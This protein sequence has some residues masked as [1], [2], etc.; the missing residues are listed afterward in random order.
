MDIREWAK[1]YLMDIDP[2]HAYSLFATEIQQAQSEVLI[3]V[4]SLLYLEYL[5]EIGLI[6]SVKKAQCN[7][8][9][10]MILYSEVGQNEVAITSQ[11]VSAI[12]IY[13]QIKCV[14]GLYGTIFLIDNSKVLT[15]NEGD[16]GIKTFAVYSNNKSIVKNIGSLLD[17]LWNEKEV[18][19]SIIAIKDN[20]ADA[21]KQL[22]E[23]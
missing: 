4:N 16:D 21:N 20:L 8:V 13:A 23:V 1:L 17:S 19:D 7:G 22:I 14:S 2:E 11:I 5:S 18:L 6:D 3:A 9:N 15:I 12:K 10:V